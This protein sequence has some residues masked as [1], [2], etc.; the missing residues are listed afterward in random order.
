ME[1]S[2][3]SP[4]GQYYRLRKTH[5]HNPRVRRSAIRHF[6]L[7]GLVYFLLCGI[8]LARRSNAFHHYLTAGLVDL[9]ESVIPSPVVATRW[10]R[11][12]GIPISVTIERLAAR[13]IRFGNFVQI[14]RMALAVCIAFV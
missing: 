13:Q 5:T 7:F 6:A 10:C 4:L 2:E 12:L 11:T 8:A 3:N 1:I 9:A 14:N